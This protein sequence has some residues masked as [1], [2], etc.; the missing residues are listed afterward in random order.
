M[1]RWRYSDYRK[2]F[3]PQEAEERLIESLKE[4]P[5]HELI[6]ALVDMIALDQIADYFNLTPTE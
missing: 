4:R 1:N 6:E 3:D 5:R 2:P